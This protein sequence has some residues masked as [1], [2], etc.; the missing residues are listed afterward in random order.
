MQRVATALVI[1]LFIAA[2][3]LAGGIWLDQFA[4]TAEAGFDRVLTAG[5]EGRFEEAR[6]SLGELQEYMKR[7]EPWLALVVRRDQ[8]GQARTSLAGIQPYLEASYWADGK[9]ELLRAR[10]QLRAVLHLYRQV[11]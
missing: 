10:E 4:D 1:L 6:V 11:L 7:C 2:A 3:V 9:L 8:L 5:D